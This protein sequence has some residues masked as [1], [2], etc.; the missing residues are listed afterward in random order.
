V[1]AE[2][3]IG[4]ETDSPVARSVVDSTS[5]LGVEKTFSVVVVVV[6]AILGWVSVSTSIGAG[7]KSKGLLEDGV[8]GV[9]F[10]SL[11]ATFIEACSSDPLGRCCDDDIIVATTIVAEGGVSRSMVERSVGTLVG[12]VGDWEEDTSP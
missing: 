1:V 7:I 9:E 5:L 2:G 8:A 10:V 3:S 4:V 6:A 12:V 11:L